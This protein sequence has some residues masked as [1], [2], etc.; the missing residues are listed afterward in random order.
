MKKYQREGKSKGDAKPYPR[1]VEGEDE[2][3]LRF[4]TA[5][6]MIVS[7]SIR[8]EKLPRIKLLLQ[9]YLLTYTVVRGN[10]NH[11]TISIYVRRFMDPRT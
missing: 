4:A 9:E 6:K 7:R 5:L 10:H 11:V 3:F 2:N 8:L 1:M